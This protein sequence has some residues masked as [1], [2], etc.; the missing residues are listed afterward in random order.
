MLIMFYSDFHIKDYSSY[1][2]FNQIS[3]QSGL[4]LELH[5]HILAGNFIHDKIVELK[6]DYL[7][8]LGDTFNNPDAVSTK[9]LYTANTI[10][11]KIKSTGV[12]HFIIEGNHDILNSNKKI[13]S[14]KI[15]SPYVDD[16]IDDYYVLSDK[17][18]KIS[19][20]P[21]HKEEMI[22]YNNI[23]KAKADRA[24]IICTHCDFKGSI[25]EEGFATKCTLD[26]KQGIKIFSGHIHMPQTV[27]DVTFIGS[28]IQYGF[29]RQQLSMNGISTYNTDTGEYKRYFNNYS[30][31]Y[32]KIKDYDNI[33]KVKD[34][35]TNIILQVLVKDS[36]EEIKALQNK[37]INYD[38]YML[39]DFSKD[40]NTSEEVSNK[41]T[42]YNINSY[43]MFENYVK[44]KKPEA[45]EIL[46]EINKL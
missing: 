41:Y 10:F 6:P 43:S 15:L 44:S 22:M 19:L 12:K 33:D 45:I 16:I 9:T 38:Y 34:F 7:I 23:I 3:E 32:L 17:G 26:S 2:K 28:V 40:K 35:N 25:F 21:Y 4:T 24:N 5:N 36:D 11:K 14:T 39:K 8:N 13:S 1:F 46:E 29:K 20:F 42:N 31:H 18:Y 27:N 37:L 30:R